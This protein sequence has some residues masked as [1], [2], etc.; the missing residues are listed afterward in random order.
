[1][2]V[3]FE[4]LVACT[5]LKNNHFREDCYGETRGLYYLRNKDKKEIDFLITKNKKPI[6]MIETKWKDDRLSTNF[7]VFSK[8][9]PGL[10]DKIQVVRELKR[11]RTTSSG[12]QIRKVS[13]WLL[14]I[15]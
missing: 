3:R 5:L 8:D 10:V 11:D 2:G 13:S 15:K 7:D 9:I 6:Q 4:N 14:S 1:M 12:H